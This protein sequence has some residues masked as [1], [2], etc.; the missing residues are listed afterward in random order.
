[1]I[2]RHPIHLPMTFSPF[3]RARARTFRFA[4]ASVAA[5]LVF[6][7]CKTRR[8][9]DDSTQ[10]TAETVPA[11]HRNNLAQST[12]PSSLLHSQAHSP[13][14]WQ[15]W[16]KQ[17]FAD[18]AREK[19]TV[20]VLIG[21]GSDSE[22]AEIL[23][24]INASPAT[25]SALN[26]AHV[27]VLVDANQQPELAYL[28]TALTLSSN[29]PG[30]STQ[31]AWFSHE[32]IPISWSGVSP[33]QRNVREFLLPMISTVNKLWQDDPDYVIGNSR[34]DIKR[35][36]AAISPE[37]AKEKDPLATLRANRQAASLF[38]PT[39]NSVDNIGELSVARYTELMALAATHPDASAQQRKHYT[40]IATLT[41]DNIIIQGLIDPLDGGIYSGIQQST[42]ALPVFTKTLASQAYAMKAL[43]QL[44]RLTHEARHLAAAESLRAYLEKNLK[45]P[46][47]GYALGIIYAKPGVQDNPCIWSLE[48]IE[49]ALTKEETELCVRAFGIS[50]LGNIPL[51]DDRNRSYFRKNTLTWKTS[52]DDLAR[53]SG[54]S[55][56]ELRAKMSSITKKLSKLRTEKSGDLKTDKLSTAE[57]TALLASAYVA[58]FRSTRSPHD[59]EKASQCLSFIRENFV[60][61]EGK[62]RR[63]RYNG[64]L[65]SIPATAG[66]YAGV[67]AAAL[68]LHEATLDPKWLAWA[69]KLHGEMTASLCDPDLTSVKETD[70]SEYPYPFSVQ[71]TR[72]IRVLDNESS[73]ALAYSNASRLGMR[74]SAPSLAKLSRNIALRS[75]TAASASPLSSIDFLAADTRLSQKTVYLRQP[76]QPE[77]LAAALRHPCQIT[78]VTADGSFPDLADSAGLLTS[79]NAVVVQRGEA[80][81]SAATA[82][83]LDKLLR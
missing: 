27:N 6:S 22:S 32:G 60:T 81:G 8:A 26:K 73:T 30:T 24:R 38:D 67:C 9:G 59:L 51:V 12:R 78:L 68:D 53:Q 15:T 54:M 82:A 40:R 75:Q 71:R 1:M 19:K 11:L 7:A 20:F 16:S 45:L 72:S 83:D 55:L 66:D 35:R 42:S 49:A 39:S 41:A 61:P 34:E 48:E 77:L 31:L 33:G 56:D 10:E 28:V 80:V 64:K 63:C 25:Y 65:L 37:P 79:E 23:R 2:A 47:G 14:H 57:T 43:H 62:L 74:S 5:S 58:A 46:D 76:A 21:S 52:M 18:A 29:A 44:Y 4:L 70:G 17:V 50:G 69:A 13:V 3:Q 36:L